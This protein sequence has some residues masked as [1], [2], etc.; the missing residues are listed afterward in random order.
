M[1]FITRKVIAVAL[2]KQVNIIESLFKKKISLGM[3]VTLK[4]KTILQLNKEQ[5]ALLENKEIGEDELYKEFI[6]ISDTL[7]LLMK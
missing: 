4:D 2:Q 3:D 7:K 1:N 5:I 6:E